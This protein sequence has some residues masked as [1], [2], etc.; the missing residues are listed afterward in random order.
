MADLASF[1][2]NDAVVR[3]DLTRAIEQALEI[4]Y[5]LGYSST[6]ELIVL[7]DA[8]LHYAPPF[9]ESS[10]IHCTVLSHAS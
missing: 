8:M 9:S 3:M 5:Q 4:G 1:I 7:L 6:E 2:R 10:L